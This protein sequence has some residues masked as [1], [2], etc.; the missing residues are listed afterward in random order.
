MSIANSSFDDLLRGELT[1]VFFDCV[2]ALFNE[3]VDRAQRIATPLF[4]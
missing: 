3:L 4:A 2:G 1:A